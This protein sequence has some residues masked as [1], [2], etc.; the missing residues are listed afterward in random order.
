M[1]CLHQTLL[2]AGERTESK[3]ERQT[4]LITPAPVEKFLGTEKKTKHKKLWNCESHAKL[5]ATI[6]KKRQKAAADFVEDANLKQLF[7][8]KQT[9]NDFL[10][11]TMANCLPSS[12]SNPR[13]N[14]LPR[15]SMR[16]LL[17]KFLIWQKHLSSQTTCRAT[18][19]PGQPALVLA[20]RDKVVEVIMKSSHYCNET[21]ISAVICPPPKNSI[22]VHTGWQMSR[23]HTRN[24]VCLSRQYTRPWDTHIQTR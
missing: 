17:S 8:L 21:C 5:Y 1:F 7:T 20:S 22:D 10:T 19:A 23:T 24:K 11:P 15:T 2:L 14:A 16:C 3:K 4:R 18:P 9:V 6:E 12:R 13:A